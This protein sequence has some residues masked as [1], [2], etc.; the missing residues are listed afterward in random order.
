MRAKAVEISPHDHSR[1]WC[2]LHK[3]RAIE[4]AAEAREQERLTEL[5]PDWERLVGIGRNRR[6]ECQ[7]FLAWVAQ[8]P[9]EIVEA[10]A[11]NAFQIVH[12]QQA[13]AVLDRYLADPLR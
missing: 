3:A 13:A 2:A 10:V 5:V 8:Q 11:I 4:L 1:L 12:A 6:R 7:A 9:D